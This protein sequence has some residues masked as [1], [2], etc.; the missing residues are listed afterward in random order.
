MN[1]ARVILTVAPNGARRTK[2]EHGAVPLS[3]E[4]IVATARASRAAGASILHLHVRDG[5]GMHS[6]D[7]AR[8]REAYDAVRAACDICIQPTTERGSSF[9]PD[10]MM[11]VQRALA[12]EMITLNLNELLDPDDDAQIARGR[13][14]LSEIASAGTVPQYIVYDWTQLQ[15]LQRWWEAGWVPQ[16]RP[17]VLLVA[18]RNGTKAGSPRDVLDYLPV[19]P[20]EWRWGVCAF[21]PHEL[22]CV[23]QAALAG[24]HC[25]VGFENN[26]TTADGRPLRDNA[27]Q[28]GR[29][30]RLLNELGFGLASAAEVREVFG[31]KPYKA[32]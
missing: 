19:L 16:R 14:F 6:L 20:G 28:V 8:Y 23:T 24:G 31:M 5:E 15:T 10:D 32:G 1:R 26:L 2:R 9:T 3:T 29:L 4:E 27:D 17:F 7:I 22:A 11:A 13:D 21:G 12:P 30:A 18:G 25:R